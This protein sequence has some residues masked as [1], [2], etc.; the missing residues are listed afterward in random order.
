MKCRL[1]YIALAFVEFP[2]VNMLKITNVF[3]LKHLYAN[4]EMRTGKGCRPLAWKIWYKKIQITHILIKILKRSLQL[5][6]SR[7]K[8]CLLPTLSRQFHCYRRIARDIILPDVISCACYSQNRHGLFSLTK[9]CE[10]YQFR[11]RPH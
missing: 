11:I 10:K 7:Y 2:A 8:T 6:I 5:T 1:K 9:F 4:N 3:H